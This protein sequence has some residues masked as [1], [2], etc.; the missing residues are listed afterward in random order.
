MLDSDGR[1]AAKTEPRITKIGVDRENG[2]L[3]FETKNAAMV[4]LISNG[5]LLETKK[6]SEAVFDL[7][8]YDGALGDYVRAEVFGEGGI[9]YTQAFLLNENSKNKKESAV[10][11]GFFDFGFLDFLLGEFNRLFSVVGRKVGR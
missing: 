7:N 2:V 5:K 3:S 9:V 10:E 8:D 6:A 11:K 1:L 4:R